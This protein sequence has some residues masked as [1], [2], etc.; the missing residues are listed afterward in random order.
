MGITV[1]IGTIT[2][3]VSKGDHPTGRVSF[4]GMINGLGYRIPLYDESGNSV[5]DLSSYVNSEGFFLIQFGW[6]PSD[7]QYMAN[8]FLHGRIAVVGISTG[9]DSDGKTFIL[10]EA[11]GLVNIHFAIALCL[12]NISFSPYEGS[13]PKYVSILADFYLAISK[14]PIPK[15]LN[16]IVKMTPEMLVAMGHPA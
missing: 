1:N 15:M 10:T 16:T 5:S 11:L 4:S 7:L 3:R 12:G 9:T 2:G 14:I 8:T 13:T 6:D